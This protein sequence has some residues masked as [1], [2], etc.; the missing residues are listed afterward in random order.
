MLLY[1]YHYIVFALNDF[2]KRKTNKEA[3]SS[4]A[5]AGLKILMHLRIALN[6][7]SPVPTSQVM[8]SAEGMSHSAWL[9]TYS[10]P[11]NVSHAHAYIQIAKEK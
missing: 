6:F 4:V 3:G 5:Q 2:K 7:F 9:R 10:F 8:G 11:S 1:N